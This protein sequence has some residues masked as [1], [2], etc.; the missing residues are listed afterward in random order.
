MRITDFLEAR[1]AEDE[2]RA[3]YVLKWGDWGG[4]FKP[5]RVLAECA[6]KRAV[7][8]LHRDNGASQGDTDTGYGVLDHACAT[9]GS[10]GEYGEE[11][12]CGTVTALA[13]VYADHPDYQQ[14]WAS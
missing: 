3:E 9:C 7:L 13:S 2:E 1:I 10:F 12:P 6:A 11:F 8:T 5:P 14:K 4:L